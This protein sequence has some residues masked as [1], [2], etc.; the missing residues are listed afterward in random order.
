VKQA[1]VAAMYLAFAVGGA[2]GCERRQ[3]P[4]ATAPAVEVAQHTAV[5]HGERPTHPRAKR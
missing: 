5:A 3:H 4:P 1:I 2:R